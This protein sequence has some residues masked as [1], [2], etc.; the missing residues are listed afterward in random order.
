MEVVDST[1]DGLHQAAGLQLGE[2]PLAVHQHVE[3]LRPSQPTSQESIKIII[4]I[5]YPCGNIQV[6]D[7][8]KIL[9]RDNGIV[10]G[11]HVRVVKSLQYLN[12]TR[13]RGKALT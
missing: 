6:H 2:A 12:F 7:N 1:E 11:D 13:N 10:Q 4:I 3:Q 8:V 9:G 5:N